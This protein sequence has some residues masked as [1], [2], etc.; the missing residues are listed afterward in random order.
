M[1][2]IPGIFYQGNNTGYQYDHIWNRPINDI[3]SFSGPCNPDSVCSWNL[4]MI[5][6]YLKKEKEA[7][8]LEIR[9]NIYL[10][11]HKFPGLHFRELQRKNNIGIGNLNHH[12]NYLQKLNLI[13][14]E[15]SK[16]NKRFYPLGLNDHERNILGV[17]R[18][19]KFRLIILKLLK[20]KSITHKNIIDYLKISPSSITWYL[21]QLIDRNILI[22]LEKEKQKH[23][24]LENKDEIIKVLVTYRESFVDKLVDSFVDAFEKQ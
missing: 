13:K 8:L 17:L 21:S 3:Y 10:T 5:K 2:S 20:E 4:Q 15:K 11:I 23:Y 24:Q 14:I 7:L 9:K 19:K 22:M 1:R 12:L 6:D 16:G 18:Q